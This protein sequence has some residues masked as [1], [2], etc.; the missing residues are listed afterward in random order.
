MSVNCLGFLCV[1]NRRGRRGICGT[2]WRDGRSPMQ[3]QQSH[4][5]A[6]HGTA[7]SLRPATVAQNYPLHTRADQS[8]APQGRRFLSAKSTPWAWQQLPMFFWNCIL[9]ILFIQV[10]YL[11]LKAKPGNP[12]INSSHSMRI[13]FPMS[14]I[15]PWNCPNRCAQ[16]IW[17]C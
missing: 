14:A 10:N 15:M 17:Q 9:D 1:L 8:A 3:C 4:R 13:I 16:P 12:W 11:W 5:T 6:R 2:H 7:L